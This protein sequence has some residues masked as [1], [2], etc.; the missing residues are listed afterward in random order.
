MH[1]VSQYML[2]KI[3]RNLLLLFGSIL[4]SLAIVEL[5]L[6]ALDISYPNFYQPDERRGYSLRPNAEGIFS[7]EGRAYVKIN[8]QGLRAPEYAV[9]K[10]EGV[11]RVAVIGDSFAEAGQVSWPQT[12]ASTAESSLETCPFLEDHRVEVINFGVGG[13]GTAQELLTWREPASRYGADIVLLLLFPGND[14]RN[15]VRSLEQ[16]SS[17]HIC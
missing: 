17:D 13:Y 7:A 6:R 10:G 8:S 1:P 12:F 4:F 11:F 9:E 16:T 15:N 5:S 3:V 14:L 2:K